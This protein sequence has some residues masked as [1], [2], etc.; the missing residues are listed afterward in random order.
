MKQR[1]H[2]SEAPFALAR[3]KQDNLKVRAANLCTDNSVGWLQWVCRT[4]GGTDFLLG[5]VHPALTHWANVLHTFGA[6]KRGTGAL[7]CPWR[8]APVGSARSD[9]PTMSHGGDARVRFGGAQAGIH[10][11]IR[12][13]EGLRSPLAWPRQRTAGLS[14]RYY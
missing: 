7:Q 4:S 5:F 3:G 9:S 11:I 2:A 12:Y 13:G 8:R 6:L 14:V 10:L 1:L